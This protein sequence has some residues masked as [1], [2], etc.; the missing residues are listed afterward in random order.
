MSYTIE[1]FTDEISIIILEVNKEI[2]ERK[3]GVLGDGN[4]Y[5][6]ELIKSELE[7]IRQQA[8]TNTLPEKSKRFTAFSK[9]VVDEWE[10]DSPLGIKL[11]KLADKFKRKI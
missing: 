8:Q 6:L 2:I 1:G 3:S 7:Q 5:Q 10:V 4:V 11:C 9:Y